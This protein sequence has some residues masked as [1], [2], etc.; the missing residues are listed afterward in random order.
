MVRGRIRN[1]LHEKPY[2]SV[3][4][5]ANGDLDRIEIEFNTGIDMDEFIRDLRKSGI[6]TKDRIIPYHS[7]EHIDVYY[8]L[9][10]DASV[11]RLFD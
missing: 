3:V 5:H 7:I 6:R 2:I 8:L 4:Y 9:Y 10:G 1:P 11:V